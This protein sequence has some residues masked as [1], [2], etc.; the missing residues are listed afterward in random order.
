MQLVA[1]YSH[2]V[3]LDSYTFIPTTLEI[4]IIIAL[5]CSGSI[6]RHL[7]INLCCTY[8]GKG[9]FWCYKMSKNNGKGMISFHIISEMQANYIFSVHSYQM[10]P[11]SP[12]KEPMYT[13]MLYVHVHI[14]CTLRGMGH[15]LSQYLWPKSL[16]LT[17]TSPTHNM[18]LSISTSP[19]KQL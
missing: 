4:T 17:F 6:T 3:R 10:Y 1:M 2:R 8:I 19:L 15:K 18:K 14:A 11:L 9:M 5:Q 12:L 16:H 7:C 13:Y